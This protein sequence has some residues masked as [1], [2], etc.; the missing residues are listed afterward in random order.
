M[1]VHQQHL[2]REQMDL[3]V[4]YAAK[5]LRQAQPATA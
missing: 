4:Q 5:K 1:S 2:T 3:A